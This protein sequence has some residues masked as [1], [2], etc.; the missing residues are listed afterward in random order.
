M[1]GNLLDQV[2]P[3]LW[4]GM[5]DAPLEDAAPVAVCGDLNTVRPGRVINK[6]ALARPKPLEAPLHD[7]VAVQ[8]LDEENDPR[9][10]RVNHQATLLLGGQ[11]LHQLLHRPGS[12]G[13]QRDGHQVGLE[14]D[15]LDQVKP[16]LLGAPIQELL[17]EVIPERVHHERRRVLQ[18]LGEDE[19][20]H[21]VAALVK[22][23]LQKPADVLVPRGSE[24]VAHNL[25]HRG[26]LHRVVPLARVVALALVVSAPPSVLH[27]I[28]HTVVAVVA[29]LPIPVVVAP[30]AV[31]VPVV[32]VPAPATTAHVHV[33]AHVTL[34]AVELVQVVGHGHARGTRPGGSGGSG[35]GCSREGSGVRDV[36]P[37]HPSQAAHPLL[38]QER[39]RKE[40][41]RCLLLLLLLHHDVERGLVR[42][43][44]LE[45]AKDSLRARLLLV[46]LTRSLGAVD[47]AASR[48]HAGGGGPGLAAK[49]RAAVVPVP[50]PLEGP[51][52]VVR[53]GVRHGGA[54][55]GP[56]VQQRVRPAGGL[57]SVERLELAEVVH[58]VSEPSHHAASHG[59]GLSSHHRLV[60]RR[61]GRVVL[62]VG[63]VGLAPRL[64]RLPALR[65][66]PAVLLVKV[67][68]R[69]VRGVERGGLAVLDEPDSP[70]EGAA[71]RE[72]E[73][74]GALELAGRTAL[75]TLHV[76]RGRDG[77]RKA[78]V[79]AAGILAL[80]LPVLD[81]LRGP[82]GVLGLQGL[83]RVR[84]VAEER[85]VVQEV[86]Q[87]PVVLLPGGAADRA[88]G[89]ESAVWVVA[90]RSRAVG[91]L[92]GVL[93]HG[94][95]G[96][97]LLRP[98]RTVSS[99]SVAL[100]VVPVLR[101]LGRSHRGGLLP[102]SL[103]GL[104]PVTLRALVAL[105]PQ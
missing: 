104:G 35:R 92:P 44:V 34:V 3:L 50:G 58:L 88:P 66:L 103:F 90:P 46:L 54:V 79:R 8:V 75:E 48:A 21:L 43:L 85:G 30:P 70:R 86:R 91:V 78:A 13:V 62:V 25:V 23:L 45:G 60:P 32:V 77:A 65:L 16:L 76:G 22:L 80:G 96:L 19:L 81:L 49:L 83:G 56:R 41:G 94:R 53:P 67:L 61:R 51:E 89:K 68:V 10:E 7:V 18:D 1:L 24:Q 64:L 26:V 39:R 6:L 59:G 38:V 11:R 2:G 9:L 84:G 47:R 98:R 31:A 102:N 17:D 5:V 20:D 101:H 57:A 63:L 95:T 73:K 55:R 40:P 37:R 71:A 29:V 93:A 27:A 100:V 15:R 87:L 28:A 82:S 33:H 12:V 74:A 69:L 36:T 99:P 4:G 105:V 42:G 14:R 97:G 52:R 72:V